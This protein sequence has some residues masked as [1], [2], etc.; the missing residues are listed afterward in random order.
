MIRYTDLSLD[1]LCIREAVNSI[2]HKSYT[3]HASAHQGTGLVATDEYVAEGSPR[4]GNLGV[5]GV[6]TTKH[7]TRVMVLNG[8]NISTEATC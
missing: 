2:S 7:S 5:M 3:D 6:T 4:S 1:E 8:F